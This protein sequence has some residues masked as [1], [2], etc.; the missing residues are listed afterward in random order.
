MLRYLILLGA[1]GT[2][3]IGYTIFWFSLSGRME[4]GIEQWARAAQS[5]GMQIEY[6]AVSVSGYPFRLV[7]SVKGVSWHF[8]TSTGGLDWQAGQLRLVTEPWAKD[9]IIVLFDPHQTLTVSTAD[10]TTKRYVITSDNGRASLVSQRPAGA[11]FAF[12]VNKLDILASASGQHMAAGEMQ[13]YLRDLPPKPAGKKGDNS[14]DPSLP[15]TAQVDFMAKDVTL[16][17]GR[18]G[19]LGDR[20]TAL[21]A[22]AVVNGQVPGLA[23]AQLKG[24]VAAG[25]TM[26]VTGFKANW[27]NLDLEAAGTLTLD[28]SNRPLGAFEARF[29]GIQGVLDALDLLG[30]SDNSRHLAR[31]ALQAAEAGRKGEW[32]KVPFTLQNGFLYMGSIP[33][34]ALSPITE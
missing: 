28:D 10:G 4:D 9:H 15:A 29:K 30:E 19:G 12:A 3:I 11:R 26:D 6:K 1:L 5:Q 23:A 14:A 16:P 2:A 31:S 21:Q 33:L 18:G 20:I 25:G 32:I 27:G 22:E 17:T 8:P 24:W 34:T 7:A 13:F